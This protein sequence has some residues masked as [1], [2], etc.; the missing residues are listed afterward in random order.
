MWS[1]TKTCPTFS[2]YNGYWYFYEDVGQFAPKWLSPK[3]AE[4]PEE[5]T[6]QTAV[7]SEQSKG[8]TL[9]ELYVKINGHLEQTYTLS[10]ELQNFNWGLIEYLSW[11]SKDEKGNEQSILMK[12]ILPSKEDLQPLLMQ[13]DRC[14]A[15]AVKLWLEN[16][17]TKPTAR[18]SKR[19][20]LAAWYTWYTMNQQ[21]EVEIGKAQDL[22]NNVQLATSKK[23]ADIDRGLNTQG[24]IS[25]AYVNEIHTKCANYTDLLDLTIQH[26]ERDRVLALEIRHLEIISSSLNVP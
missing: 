20:T 6:P 8:Q 19:L 18:N 23:F 13:S 14:N 2:Q 25:E 11:T 1:T 24:E 4:K 9:N 7:I 22:A 12:D 3:E 17:Y 21:L 5:G 26:L 16:P 15:F 10:Q